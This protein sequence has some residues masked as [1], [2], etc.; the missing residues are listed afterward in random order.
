M[1]I[2]FGYTQLNL[3]N[4]FNFFQS[5]RNT[6]TAPSDCLV[7]Y[8]GHS[9][10]GPY[11]SAEKQSVYSTALAG[12]VIWFYAH[13]YMVGL[14]DVLFYGISTFVGHLTPNLYLCK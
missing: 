4:Q 14:L 5:S 10:V 8:S 1:N 6:G 7:L 12:W 13:S 9:L 2:G 11:P 3:K